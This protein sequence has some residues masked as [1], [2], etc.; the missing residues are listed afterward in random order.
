MTRPTKLHR[1]ISALAFIAVFALTAWDHAHHGLRDLQWPSIAILV[2]T[3]PFWF[4]VFATAAA[5]ALHYLGFA[6]FAPP[7]AA[8]RAITG[9]SPFDRI[10]LSPKERQAKR[11]QKLAREEPLRRAKLEAI[12]QRVSRPAY[13]PVHQHNTHAPSQKKLPTN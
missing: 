7:N 12:A 4:P 5:H 6:V 11:R 2:V 8:I 9:A 1:L 3:A 13:E 10:A